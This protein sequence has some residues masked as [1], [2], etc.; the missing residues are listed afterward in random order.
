MN[1]HLSIAAALAFVL[2]PAAACAQDAVRGERLFNDAA[3]VIGNRDIVP[4]VGCHG[5]KA[6]LREM[7]T[8]RGGRVDDVKQLAAWIDA[9]IAGAQPGAKNA[10][11]QY[12]GVLSRKDVLD[13]AAYLARTARAQAPPSGPQASALATR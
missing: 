10:K 7:I 5:D 6:A 11:A 8:N 4:C 3:A 9:V 1:R 12:R 13:L 2:L